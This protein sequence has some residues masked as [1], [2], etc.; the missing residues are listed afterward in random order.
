[1]SVSC[2]T[3]G[4]EVMPFSMPELV[5]TRLTCCVVGR[6]WKVSLHETAATSDQETVEARSY[7]D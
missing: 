1:M 2:A 3:F 5:P 4:G 6:T 7:I